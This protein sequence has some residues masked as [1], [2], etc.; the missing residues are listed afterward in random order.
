MDLDGVI[1]IGSSPLPGVPEFFKA[2]ADL[3]LRY[4]LLTNNST[5]TTEQFVAK[6]RG[7]GV[8]ASE[9]EILTSASATANYLTQVAPAGAGVYVVGETGLREEVRRRGF[10]VESPNPGY[11]V[12]GMDRGFTY[13]KLHRTCNL[14]IGG[15]VFIGSNP[16]TT[17]PTENGLIP[18]CGTLL[19]AMKTCSGVE[20]FIVGKPGTLMLEQAMGRMGVDRSVTGMLGDRLDTDIVAGASAG[21]TNIMVLTGI[22]TRDE[23]A[24]SPAK[25]DYVYTDLVDLAAALRAAKTGAPA[26]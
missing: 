24:I 8:P 20:P 25:P 11:V 2:L 3:H 16:D 23:I 26:V 6:V 22:S 21:V 5:L 10:D 12:V 19:A 18:G 15:A 13:E 17:L 1:Y 7:M 14:L 9:S 4:T